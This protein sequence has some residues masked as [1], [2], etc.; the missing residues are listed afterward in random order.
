MG[1]WKSGIV[2][3]PLQDDSFKT[4]R[5]YQTEYFV[6]AGDPSGERIAL[7]IAVLGDS[8]SGF[9]VYTDYVGRDGRILSSDVSPTVNAGTAQRLFWH[10]LGGLPG[11]TGIHEIYLPEVTAGPKPTARSVREQASVEET[12]RGPLANQAAVSDPPEPEPSASIP[13]ARAERP[14]ADMTSGTGLRSGMESEMEPGGA[15]RAASTIPDAAPGTAGGIERMTRETEEA[16]SSFFDGGQRAT[17]QLQAQLERYVDEGGNWALGAIGATGLGFLNLSMEFAKGMPLSL[18]DARRLGEGIQKGTWEGV[19]EDASRLAAILPQGR[20]A[21]LLRAGLTGADIAEA[22][23]SQ[24]G[25]ALA[26]TAATAAVGALLG[27]RGGRKGRRMSSSGSGSGS[28]GGSG[29]GSGKGTSDPLLDR[30]FARNHVSSRKLTPRELGHARRRVQDL[31]RRLEKIGRN[32]STTAVLIAEDPRTGNLVRLVSSSR[33]TLPRRIR[34][35]LSRS[36]AACP[37]NRKSKN[38]SERD[39]FHHAEVNALQTAVSSGFKVVAIAPS[40]SACGLCAQVRRNL[41]VTILDP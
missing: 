33:G 29:R 41:G 4:G 22:A 7:R 16:V 18:L 26:P 1:G 30:D 2:S 37:G 3:G 6:A 27:A 31:H 21:R 19:K 38:A 34:A 15:E 32:R 5:I 20:A 12:T 25:R 11:W 8:D 36:E 28:G 9:R 40:R 39:H 14:M 35:R 10:H 24:D 13:R 23:A 17:G